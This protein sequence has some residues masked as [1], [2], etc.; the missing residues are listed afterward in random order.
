MENADSLV[1][2]I[3]CQRHAGGCESQSGSIYTVYL[4]VCLDVCREL[5]SVMQRMCRVVPHLLCF[6]S[7]Q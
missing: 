6:S 1:S 4:F 5:D 2:T 3:S 7:L